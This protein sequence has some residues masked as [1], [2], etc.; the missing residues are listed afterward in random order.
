MPR[1]SGPRGAHLGAEEYR[2]TARATDLN[3]RLGL[4]RRAT[5]VGRSFLPS[6]ETRCAPSGAAVRCEAH[7]PDENTYAVRVFSREHAALGGAECHAATPPVPGDEIE[8]RMIHG[9]V[10]GYGAMSA[11]ANVRVISVDPDRQVIDAHL[12]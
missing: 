4:A 2:A 12:V 9:N 8:V 6:A 11:T 1:D 5:R 10:N 3:A 7:L